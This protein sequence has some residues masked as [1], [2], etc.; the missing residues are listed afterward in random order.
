VEGRT[1][2]AGGAGVRH[3]PSDTRGR[4]G[5]KRMISCGLELSPGP[6]SRR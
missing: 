3:P 2:P 6:S 1:P 4:H 5:P